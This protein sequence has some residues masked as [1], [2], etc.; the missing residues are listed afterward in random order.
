MLGNVVNSYKAGGG[1]I[2]GFFGIYV[3]FWSIKWCF[4]SKK[5]EDLKREAVEKQLARERALQA[6]QNLE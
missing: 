2:F 5:R 4:G 3:T 1:L 6:M